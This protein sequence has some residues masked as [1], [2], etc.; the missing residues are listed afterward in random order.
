VGKIQA[1]IKTSFGRIIVEGSSPNELL[2]TLKS[3]PE[4][5]VDELEI[6]ISGSMFVGKKGFNE[7]V[8][9][10]DE[11]PILISK[12][13]LTHYEAVGLTIYFSKNKTSTASQINRLL[14][15][16]G[17]KIQVSSRLNEMAW[18]G[19]IYKPDPSGSEWRLSPKG[20]RW[21]EEN[22]LARLK[23]T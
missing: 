1:E 3:L 10:T 18:K 20:E 7:I 14:E 15:C 8:R 22:V 13:K 21:L 5:F 12:S 17:M 9:L 2:E 6:I 11:G 16:A 23:T 19:L 4:N